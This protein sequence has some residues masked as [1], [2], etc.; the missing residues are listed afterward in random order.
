MQQVLAEGW[1]VRFWPFECHDPANT[2]SLAV[3]G[4][5]ATTISL[6]FCRLVL[7]KAGP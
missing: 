1:F 2:S 6:H 5:F 7:E 3:Y 4:K